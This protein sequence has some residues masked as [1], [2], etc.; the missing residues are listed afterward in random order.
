MNIS[1]LILIIK[2]AINIENINLESSS[3][4]TEEW[5][6]LGHLSI[7]VALD[8]ELNGKLSSIPEIA[9][10]DSVEAIIAILRKN[11]LI[12]ES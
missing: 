4:N 2:K 12:D 3:E 11:H 7:L 5:D 1:D 6:S 9:T 8:K 10:A